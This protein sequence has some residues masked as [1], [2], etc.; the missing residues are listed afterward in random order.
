MAYKKPTEQLLDDLIKH[1]QQKENDLSKITTDMQTKIDKFTGK[2]RPI[3]D[4]D[5]MQQIDN[6]NIAIA[7]L[8]RVIEDIKP[9]YD[10]P[11]FQEK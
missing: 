4:L 10:I 2:N 6:N 7:V 9:F 3:A 5:I 11:Y 8:N 1:F